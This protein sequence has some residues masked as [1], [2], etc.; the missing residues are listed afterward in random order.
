MYEDFGIIGTVSSAGLTT[1]KLS[2]KKAQVN[3]SINNA[4]DQAADNEIS[5]ARKESLKNIA[6]AGTS[7]A[8]F[9]G[10][11]D[12]IGSKTK[13]LPPTSFKRSL[14]FAGLLGG[15]SA[16]L[17]AGREIK[18]YNRKVKKIKELRDHLK[19]GNLY[20]QIE[21]TSEVGLTEGMAMG[22]ARHLRP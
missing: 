21:K 13:L 9:S 2:E 3:P 17:Q 12:L 4:I 11:V 10:A 5:K 15:V 7:M 1:H 6:G 14:G 22:Q 18:P 8:A 20:P 19:K 16:G